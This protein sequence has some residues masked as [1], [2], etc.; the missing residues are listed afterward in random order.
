MT[1]MNTE[2]VLTETQF[3]TFKLGAED[4]GIA[5]ENVKEI[6]EIPAVTHIPATP[7]Y[8]EGVINLRGEIL[9]VIDVR[10]RFGMEAAERSEF[11]RIIVAH[12]RGQKI[13]LIVDSVSEVLQLRGMTIQPPPPITKGV[14]EKYLQGVIE[15]KDEK[16]IILLLNLDELISEEE[17][18]GALE[19]EGVIG[20]EAEERKMRGVEESQLVTFKLGRE[21]YGVEIHEVEEIIDMPEVT[22]VPQSPDF[23]EGVISLRGEIIP[24]V[25]LDVRFGL[26][27]THRPLE[28]GGLRWG[29]EGRRDSK[30][31]SVIIVSISGFEVGLIVDEVSEVLR[32]PNDNIVPP[33]PHISIG[34]EEQ[35]KGVVK[36]RYG[37]NVRLIL[38]LNLSNIF[39][40]DM[41][42]MLKTIGKERQ[43]EGVEKKEREAVE[44]RITI[45]TFRVGED[46]FGIN[47]ERLK[48]ITLVP[49]ITVVPRSP[50]F[51][52]GVINLRG[53]VIAVID[54]R[55]RFFFPPIPRDAFT[56]IIIVDIDGATTGLLVDSVT[57]VT[58]IPVS[59]VEPPPKVIS[60]I[61]TE[62][63]EGVVK[64]EGEKKMIIMLNLL[65]LLTMEEKRAVSEAGLEKPEMTIVTSVEGKS[66]RE[67]R[68]E[69]RGTRGDVKL[70]KAG[71]KE[72]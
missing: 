30:H 46:I 21:S 6:I 25:N 54:M 9:S 13:G 63:I 26:I 56:R 29:K 35:L 41:Q 70:K 38:Y 18:G 55:K 27:P 49:D 62:F 58:A 40:A 59:S 24:L 32:V 11:S 28:K 22:A 72:D 68:D 45:V 19:G 51:I 39:T 48:E 10:T 5:I 34:K 60:R 69:G 43:K 16:R 31:A 44:K 33:P 37:E 65:K 3:V 15:L 61:E 23:I 17:F 2:D 8:F 57:A 52:E 47:I 66:E 53:E 64:Q 20:K 12:M 71:L 7:D 42:E 36:V 14:E 4:F 67:T 1:G 50:S